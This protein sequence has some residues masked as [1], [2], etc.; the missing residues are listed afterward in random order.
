M[1]AQSC[2]NFLAQH[3]QQ[4]VRQFCDYFNK[5]DG[6]NSILDSFAKKGS[7]FLQDHLPRS[8]L[9]ISEAAIKSVHYVALTVLLPAPLRLAVIGAISA[10]KIAHTDARNC[11]NLLNGVG[12]GCVINAVRNI[13]FLDVIS[14][15]VNLIAAAIL[16]S[17]SPLA[18]DVSRAFSSEKAAPPSTPL[19]PST[20]TTKPKDP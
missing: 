16:F 8:V 12:C 1:M 3:V 11:E 6:P 14:C 15:A 5:L 2:V 10:H 17:V 9:L 4:P 19:E 18:N 13:L 20:E 7:L